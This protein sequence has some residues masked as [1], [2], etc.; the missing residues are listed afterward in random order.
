MSN[1]FRIFIITKL[2]FKILAFQIFIIILIWPLSP[3]IAES[4]DTS[5]IVVIGEDTLFYLDHDDI[6]TGERLFYGLLPLGENTN[7]CVSCHHIKPSDTLNWNPSAIE[8]ASFMCEKKYNELKN[9]LLTPSGNKLTEVHSNYQLNDDQIILLQGFMQEFYKE[10]GIKPKPVIDRLLLFI[11]LLMLL[12]LPVFD[13]LVTK[14]IKYKIIHLVL[15]FGSLFFITKIIVL[16]AIALGRQKTYQPLQPVKFSHKVHA[17]INRTECLYCHHTAEYGKSAGIPSL[18]VCWNC[19]AIVR[20]GTNSGKFEINKIVLAY[21]QT[22]KPFQWIRIHNLPDHVFFSHAQH[23]GSGKLDCEECHGTV[24]EMDVIYQNSDLSMGWCL[25]CHR[26]HKV[27]FMENEYYT[28]YK[29]Y[30]EKI[31]AGEMDSVLVENIGG[32]DCQRCHY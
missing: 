32:T 28:I 26:T 21:E 25:D 27:Q 23:V 18:N 29:E 19:H 1:P 31:K 16:D 9:V 11:G 30:H 5:R 3:L 14:K 22:G 20:E 24:E 17:G 10:G 2:F 6:K 15:I 7:S 12:L 4:Y 8:I 13:L